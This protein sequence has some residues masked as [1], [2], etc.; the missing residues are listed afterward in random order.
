MYAITRHARKCRGGDDSAGAKVQPAA[1]YL[2][3]TLRV[4]RTPLAAKAK[5]TS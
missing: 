3:S 5:Q 2:S 4:V 1:L